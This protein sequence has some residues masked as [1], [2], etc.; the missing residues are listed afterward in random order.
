MSWGSTWR[1]MKRVRRCRRL[2]GAGN[3][4]HV[5]RHGKGP[6]PASSDNVDWWGP[7]RR[8]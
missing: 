5:E 4:P 7:L 6:E 8:S 1:R 3:C 2:Y